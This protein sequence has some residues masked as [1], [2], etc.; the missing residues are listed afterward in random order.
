MAVETSNDGST[1]HGGQED[2][3]RR[4]PCDPNLLGD[5]S[6]NVRNVLR[7]ELKTTEST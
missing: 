2:D 5:E 6:V 3:R 4:D 7:D 1:I